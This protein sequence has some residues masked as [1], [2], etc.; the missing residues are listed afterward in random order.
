MESTI[1]QQ[2]DTHY[3]HLAQ[4]AARR[5][6]ETGQ[7][8]NRSEQMQLAIMYAALAIAEAATRQAIVVEDMQEF[9]VELVSGTDIAPALL[10]WSRA[11]HG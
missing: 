10:A 7:T 4:Q 2:N 6:E 3:L 8:C 5:V 11:H 9:L 1:T